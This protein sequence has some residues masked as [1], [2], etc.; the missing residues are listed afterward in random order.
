[1]KLIF[2]D[3]DGVLNTQND[4]RARHILKSVL[5]KRYEGN[6]NRNLD[7][8]GSD[9]FGHLFDETAVRY[10]EAL[11]ES[12][13]AYLV[14]TSTWRYPGLQKCSDMWKKRS[15]PGKIIGITPCGKYRVSDET[16]G[17]SYRTTERGWE[18][19][20]FLN[21][22]KKGEVPKDFI[23]PAFINL[24]CEVESYVILDDDRDM[25]PEQMENF[26]QCHPLY[27]FGFREYQQAVSILGECKK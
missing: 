22:I 1:M 15:L 9:S 26:I 5:I 16:Y 19:K 27:G 21:D 3:I 23:H 13:K 20:Q 8:I 10:L 7:A 14:L 4:M 18:I 17:D 6:L 11:I 2:L 25:L 24:A 12:T